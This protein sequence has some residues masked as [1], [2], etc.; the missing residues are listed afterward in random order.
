[1]EVEADMAALHQG[2]TFT[3]KKTCNRCGK[4]ICNGIFDG[5]CLLTNRPLPSVALEWTVKP[6]KDRR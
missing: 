1:M 4:V 6:G 2:T 3:Y 5:V